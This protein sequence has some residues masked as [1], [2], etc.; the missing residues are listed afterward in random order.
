MVRAYCFGQ[1]SF[2]TEVAH[3]VAQETTD[4]ELEREVVPAANCYTLWLGANCYTL[5][6]GEGHACVHAAHALLRVVLQGVDVRCAEV[7]RVRCGT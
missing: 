6:L 5:W 7:R 4:E 1:I 2:N 3:G